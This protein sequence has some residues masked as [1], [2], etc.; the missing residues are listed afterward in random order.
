MPDLLQLH[1]YILQNVMQCVK[2]KYN[3]TFLDPTMHK[4]VTEKPEKARGLLRMLH[5][6][7]KRS[8]LKISVM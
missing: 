2:K 6:P 1:C 3:N 4:R 5:V 7:E 8:D